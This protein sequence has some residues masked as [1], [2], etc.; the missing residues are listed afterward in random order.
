METR[1][2]VPS[3]HERTSR[4]LLLCGVAA[5]PVL[6]IFIAVAALVTPGYSHISETLSQ[7]GA[8]GRPYPEV[9]S[10]GFIVFGLLVNC[11]AY[12]LYQLLQNQTGSRIV[13]LLLTIYGTAILLSGIFQG[14]PKAVSTATNLES[15][16]HGVFA[17]IGFF[18]LVAGMGAFARLVS[19]DPKWPKFMPLS[20]TIAVLNLGLSLLFVMEG[21]NSVEGMLQRLFCAISLFWIVAVSLRSLKL[22]TERSLRESL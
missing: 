17:M 22:P 9:M 18:A 8:Q 7:L 10:T 3:K 21:L 13:W 12:G 6:V 5:P 20:I 19:R 15:T 1:L 11:F 14:V 16:L 2:L 4:L